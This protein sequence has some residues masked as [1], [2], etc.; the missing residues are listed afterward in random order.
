MAGLMYA[1]LGLVL[2]SF[3]NLCID[4]LPRG[5]SILTA[6]SHCDA[7]GH[8]LGPLDLVPVFSYLAL[9]GR[10]RYCLARIPLRSPLVELGTAALF[11][12]VWLRFSTS[13][14]G[15]LVALYGSLLIPILVIDLEHHRVLNALSYPAIVL[16][17]AA[18]A[19]VPGRSPWE[20]LAGG[21]LGSGLL[22]VLALLYPAGMGMGDV[23][24]AAFIGLAVG[25]PQVL[26]ALFLSFLFGG[27]ISGALV[28]AKAIGRR[29]PIAFAPF[30]AAG[31]LTTLFFGDPI[32]RWWLART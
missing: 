18:A 22:L 19:F 1:L 17:L 14:Q 29:D 16:A 12:V 21:A 11:A 7:C 2:G 25:H 27:A 6:R 30:L 15:V 5:E 3:L 9:R 24:L 28:L 20:M 13:L 23:K 26:L 32:L 31:A 4:R 10:C 8:L